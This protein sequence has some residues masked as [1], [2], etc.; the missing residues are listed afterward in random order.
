MDERTEL[1]AL[2]DA[3]ADRAL[4]RAGSAATI[5]GFALGALALVFLMLA[6]GRVD[7]TSLPQVFILGA[8]QVAG[9]VLGLRCQLAARQL[10]ADPGSGQDRAAAA[11]DL[12]RRGLLTVTLVAAAVAVWALVVLR[13]FT[14]AALSVAIG[15]ALLAQFMI[16]MH[17]QRRALLRAGPRP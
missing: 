17:L 4:R 7:A 9:L 5:G 1:T 16:L 13:P 3:L 12:L 14:S 11:A 8:G 2:A 15:S 10:A 6:E